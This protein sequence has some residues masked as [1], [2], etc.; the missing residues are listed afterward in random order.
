M[1]IRPGDLA[2]IAA[3]IPILRSKVGPPIIQTPD[4]PKSTAPIAPDPISQPKIKYEQ[5]ASGFRCRKCGLPI[6]SK[7]KIGHVCS[8]E[9]E[10]TNKQRE[11]QQKKR[12]RSESISSL[13]TSKLKV[14]P[15]LDTQGFLD[16]AK[17][18]WILGEFIFTF[19]K[20]QIPS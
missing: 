8:K 6:K 1:N 4:V 3:I 17:E 15:K 13:I 14:Q 2:K 16:K 18:V 5:K 11:P 19:F 7:S 12:K 9:S 10:T 20:F